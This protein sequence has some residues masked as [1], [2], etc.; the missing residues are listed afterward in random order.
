MNRAERAALGQR[1]LAILRQGSYVLPNGQTVDLADDLRQCVNATRVYRPQELEALAA[2]SSS[3]PE[4]MQAGTLEI[5][6][7]STIEGISTLL[8]EGST[9]VAALNFAS[10][11][12]P[13]G[14]FLTGSQAQEESLARSSGLHASLMQASEFYDHHRIAGDRPARDIHLR[15]CSKCGRPAGAPAAGAAAGA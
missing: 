11:R 3:S 9:P 12:N 8:R 15:G 13:G 1:T 6:N 4:A 2:R 14:G 7:E 10:A 5:E